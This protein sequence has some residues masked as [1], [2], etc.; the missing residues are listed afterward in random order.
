MA[1]RSTTPLTPGRANLRPRPEPTKLATLFRGSSQ[2]TRAGAAVVAA[3]HREPLKYEG[4]AKY[5]S[6][7][8]V[9]A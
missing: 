6:R 4:R 2:R 3:D 7:Y 5:L 8:S 9:L 1:K